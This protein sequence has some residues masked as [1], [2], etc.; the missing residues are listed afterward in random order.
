MAQKND[1]INLRHRP[2]LSCVAMPPEEQFNVITYTKWQIVPDRQWTPCLVFHH[3]S[4]NGFHN[5]NTWIYTLTCSPYCSASEITNTY[6]ILW[7]ADPIHMSTRVPLD[8]WHICCH[9]SHAFQNGV[10]KYNS[11][12]YCKYSITSM[13]LHGCHPVPMQNES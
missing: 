6:I 13:L 8:S 1:T 7:W 12:Q 11:S 2:T 3:L 4:E 10:C 5:L 9:V